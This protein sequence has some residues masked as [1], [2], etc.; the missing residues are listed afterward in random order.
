MKLNPVFYNNFLFGRLDR[1]IIMRAD[2]DYRKNGFGESDN[3]FCTYNLTAVP[4]PG[5]RVIMDFGTTATRIIPFVR[6]QNQQYVL[7][8]QANKQ[9]I[10]YVDVN[11]DFVPTLADDVSKYMVSQDLTSNSDQGYVCTGANGN[12]DYYKIYTRAGYAGTNIN[13]TT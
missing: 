1:K 11:G 3:V 7:A 4:R 2:L 8:M 13:N 6:G 9:S 12:L 5:T 10:Y